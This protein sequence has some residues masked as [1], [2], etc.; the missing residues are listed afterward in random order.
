M[1]TTAA[2]T[3]EP[4]TAIAMMPHCGSI[5][6]DS[7]VMGGIHT[8]IVSIISMTGGNSIY[9]GYISV[10]NNVNIFNLVNVLLQL[11]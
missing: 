1:T 8:K 3:T 5:P 6:D 2:N 4:A 7:S 9:K 10:Q 11:D